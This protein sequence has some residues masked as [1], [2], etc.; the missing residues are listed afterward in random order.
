MDFLK[1]LKIFTKHIFYWIISF[2]GF[3]TFF[4]LFGLKKIV[5]FG[6][7]LFLPLPSGNSFTVQ[8]FNKIRADLLPPDVKL[9]VTNPISA[10]VAQILL[11]MLLSFLLTTPFFIYKIILYLR[12]ALF[13]QERRA[14][15]L[16]LLPLTFLFLCGAAYSYFF[17]IPA[18]FKILYPYTTNIGAVAYFSVSEFIH[19]VF[20]LTLSVGLMFL[21]PVFMTLLSW[22]GIIRA[23]F[24]KNKWRFALLLF[25][26]GSAI[27]TPD[28]TGVTMVM[29]FLP[30]MTLYLAGY[31]FAYKLGK[32]I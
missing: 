15:I 29:L 32:E 21:L 27:I 28:G 26:I 12:P 4:F 20:G 22:L 17:L 14:V 2:V 16:S 6:Q 1:E 3:S 19:Y 18:T 24:W 5:I 23:E 9:L 10:F 7:E 25:L 11:S 31:V 8:V 30:L 13:P